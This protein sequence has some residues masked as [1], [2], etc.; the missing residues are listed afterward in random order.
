MEV[1]T[2]EWK[3]ISSLFGLMN[4][5]LTGLTCIVLSDFLRVKTRYWLVIEPS[6]YVDGNGE[7][8]TNCEIVVHATLQI[9][10]FLF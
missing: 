10:F 8:K 9:H 5:G 1:I 3:I 4:I 7:K 2:V 6:L